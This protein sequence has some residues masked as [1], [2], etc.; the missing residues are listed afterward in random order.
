[1]RIP[2]NTSHAYALGL[3]LFEF[4][5]RAIHGLRLRDLAQPHLDQLV[6]ESGE[7]AHICVFDNGEMVSVAYAEGPRSLRMPATVGRRT[8]AYCSAVGKAI[9]AFLPETAVDEVMARPLRA[10]TEKTLVTRA[11]LLADLRQVRIRGYAVDNEEIEK[12]LRCVGAPVWNYSGDVAAAVSVAGPAFR[13]TRTRVPAMARS[14]MAM[15]QRLSAE[16]GY[17]PSAPLQ[18]PVRGV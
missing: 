8:P 18:V 16:L 2:G 14:V 11:A 9:L 12:G 10:C 5:S 15:T 6:R 4:G 3:R 13:I 1:M 17:R 7:T